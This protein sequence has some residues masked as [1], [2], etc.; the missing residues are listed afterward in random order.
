MAWDESNQVI[1]SIT[2][3]DEVLVLFAYAGDPRHNKIF[4]FWSRILFSSQGISEL[5]GLSQN[6]CMN[7]TKNICSKC[8]WIE[9]RIFEASCIYEKILSEAKIIFLPTALL[10]I[11][12]T[13]KKIIA[14]KWNRGR[15]FCYLSTFCSEFCQ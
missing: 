3:V 6:V 7:A 2:K 12:W 10:T 13:E 14:A 11:F 1:L 5:L 4:F 9:I 15:I 8:R